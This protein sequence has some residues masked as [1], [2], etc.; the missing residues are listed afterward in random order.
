MEHVAAPIANLSHT[1]A[2]LHRLLGRFVD[3][4]LGQEASFF[5]SLFEDE[6][7]KPKLL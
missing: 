4:P 6:S 5:G 1:T 3:H 7:M 2:T